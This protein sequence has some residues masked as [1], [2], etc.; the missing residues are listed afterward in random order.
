MK[1]IRIKYSTIARIGALIVALIN[2]ALILFGKNALP[3]T[4]NMAY[5][6]ISLVFLVVIAGIN[7]WFNQ[8]CTKLAIICGMLFDAFKDKKITEDEL[9]EVIDFAESEEEVSKDDEKVQK[10]SFIV[11]VVNGILSLIKKKTNKSD[12]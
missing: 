1:N 4:E 11:N 5:R 10:Y 9:Q 7:M 2:S 12:E 3:F 6:V 8:D